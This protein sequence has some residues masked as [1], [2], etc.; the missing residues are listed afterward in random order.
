MSGLCGVVSVL[1]E[2]PLD[3]AIR[4]YLAYQAHPQRAGCWPGDLFARLHVY[5]SWTRC[6]RSSCL[7]GPVRLSV[8]GRL[9]KH[10]NTPLANLEAELEKIA[11]LRA[12]QGMIASA[13]NC[14]SRR[15]RWTMFTATSSL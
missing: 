15:C 9:D 7:G 5:P 3:V 6:F 12:K 4:N 2:L 11:E 14:M 10:G 1:R 13:S 8:L